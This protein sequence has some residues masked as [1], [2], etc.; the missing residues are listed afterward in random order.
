MGAGEGRI[1]LEGVG[2]SGGG[3]FESVAIVQRLS[4]EEA[5]LRVGVALCEQALED[6]VGGV[7][8]VEARIA[9]HF[10]IQRG[11]IDGV[12]FARGEKSD[13][14]LRSVSEHHA[15]GEQ[16]RGPR[17]PRLDR[18]E[19]CEEGPGLAEGFLLHV[20]EA[21]VEQKRGIIWIQ[22]ERALIDCDSF[23]E[24]VRVRVKNAEVAE[25]GQTLRISGQHSGKP[26][27]SLG[28]SA[29]LQGD[30]CVA[31][32]GFKRRTCFRRRLAEEG[33]EQGRKENY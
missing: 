31:E 21:Q 24:A 4:K 7:H 10:Q 18:I 23:C 9:D 30:R 8:L 11:G 5:C 16:E 13:A 12:E 1:E 20:G 3:V 32:G 2:E 25:G 26:G 28:V 27:F 29:S 22:L 33:R 14:L 6:G 17:I 19:T 15:G